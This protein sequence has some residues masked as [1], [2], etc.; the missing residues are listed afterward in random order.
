[1]ARD[2]AEYLESLQ[3]LSG[4]LPGYRGDNKTTWGLGQTVV[5]WL[6]G[7][8]ELELPDFLLQNAAGS[9]P[10]PDP[11]IEEVGVTSAQT[12]FSLVVRDFKIVFPFVNSDQER[13]DFF[14]FCGGANVFWK[15]G[16]FENTGNVGYAVETS[17]ANAYG[18]GYFNSTDEIDINVDA[19]GSHP[20]PFAAMP[21]PFVYDTG[22]GDLLT[23]RWQ[24]PT[25][26]AGGAIVYFTFALV[27]GNIGQAARDALIKDWSRCADDGAAS[28]LLAALGR[29]P[30]TRIP[31]GE[32]GDAV[33]VV[34]A[35]PAAAIRR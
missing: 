35:P 23:L 20:R 5:A 4:I 11:Q 29:A 33:R 9:V 8:T 24:R 32:I 10:F 21:H 22:S 13:A 3:N 15:S 19:F 31:A 14:T 28:A 27:E 18:Y 7:D 1:M 34:T 2:A 25:V 12:G 6:L 16:K 17:Q 30:S 26:A